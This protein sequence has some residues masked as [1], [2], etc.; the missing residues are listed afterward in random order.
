MPAW[1]SAGRS[2]SPC[3]ERPAGCRPKS[4]RMSDARPRRSG[5]QAWRG[6]LHPSSDARS[7]ASRD[8]SRFRIHAIGRPPTGSTPAVAPGPG[9]ASRFERS[10]RD[11]PQ[12]RRALFAG[13]PSASCGPVQAEAARRPACRRALRCQPQIA[14]SQRTS[15]WR[16]FHQPEGDR[17]AARL[18]SAADR[19]I[20]RADGPPRPS[21]HQDKTPS[22]A[23]TLSTM[24][25]STMRPAWRP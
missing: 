10:S 8:W 17:R 25:R 13:A 4:Q 19:R 23:R 9:P 24:A 16:E 5:G 14:R 1:M 18:R 2:S 3:M 15:A 7:R 6:R 22:P 11:D 20:C 21:R 12:C